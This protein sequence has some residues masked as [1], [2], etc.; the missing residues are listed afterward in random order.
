MT[1]TNAVLAKA[2]LRCITSLDENDISG[3][4]L[5]YLHLSMMP[6]RAGSYSILSLKECVVG[7]NGDRRIPV[8]KPIFSRDT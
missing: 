3:V 5:A 4:S 7:A 2:S 8:K 1:K 6:V